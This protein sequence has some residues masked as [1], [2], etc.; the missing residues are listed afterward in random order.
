MAQ[1]TGLVARNALVAIAVEP[2]APAAAV[3]AATAVEA[4]PVIAVPIPPA[5]RAAPPLAAR[6]PPVDEAMS[7]RKLPPSSLSVVTPAALA[8]RPPLRPRPFLPRP[9]RPSNP[10][11]DFL[12]AALSAT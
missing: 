4:A 7:P 11:R 6:K 5:I 3:V 9:F 10:P 12:A 1:P 2:T 8:R